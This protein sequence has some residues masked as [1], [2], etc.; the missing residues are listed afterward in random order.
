MTAPSTFTSWLPEPR[1]PATS[2][3]STISKRERLT[4]NIFILGIP[5]ASSMIGASASSLS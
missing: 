4:K 2:H 1:S 3:V 5:A